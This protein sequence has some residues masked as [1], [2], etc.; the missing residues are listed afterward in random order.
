MRA[1]GLLDL[2]LIDPELPPPAAALL[3]VI[4]MMFAVSLATLLG[5]FALPVLGGW[6]LLLAAGPALGA[7]LCAVGCGLCLHAWRR[8]RRGPWD[9]PWDDTRR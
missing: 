8:G 2:V 4:G 5:V 7:L 1:R 3:W 9:G 6:A